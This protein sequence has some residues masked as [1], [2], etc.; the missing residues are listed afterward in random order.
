M[1]KTPLKMFELA[2]SCINTEAPP[3]RSI[4]FTSQKPNFLRSLKF[5]TMTNIVAFKQAVENM[6][7]QAFFK[8]QEKKDIWVR[9]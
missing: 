6:Q 3:Q 5:L 1:D 2:V 9:V 8:I 4:R 7:K